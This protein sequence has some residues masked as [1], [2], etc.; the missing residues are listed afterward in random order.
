MDTAKRLVA[1][2]VLG[3]ALAGV[4]A[5]S[6]LADDAAPHEM[7]V[8]TAQDDNNNDNDNSSGNWGWWGLLG[9]LGLAGLA[10]RKQRTPNIADR[11]TG[12]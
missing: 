5:A 10:G 11:T 9:L 8:V 4:P 2:L 6:A 12:R 7:T 3:T 1:A